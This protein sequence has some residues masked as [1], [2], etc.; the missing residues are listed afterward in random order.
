MTKIVR[1][2]APLAVALLAAV[3]AP[4]QVVDEVRPL[5][6]ERGAV[7]GVKPALRV[8]VKGEDLVKMRFKIEL[9]RDGFDTIAATFD[10]QKDPNGWAFTDA[11]WDVKGALYQVRQ[12][13]PDGTYEWRVSAWN[14]V[15]WVAG[16]ST[17]SF[18]VDAV[19]PADVDGLTMTVDRA[20]KVIHLEWRPVQVDIEG[21]P[22]LVARYHVYRYVRK[23]FFASYAVYEVGTTED[24]AFD[25]RDEAA[26]SG[27]LLFYKVA[28]EDAAGNEQGRRIH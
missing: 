20:R 8:A 2:A 17:S 13:L 14:G 28:A 15:D 11:G 16:K 5:E 1:I 3:R 19:P 27:N 7:V 26:F 25:D 22:E 6:P 21:H 12:D 10:Q 23:W 4:A 24:T 9:S 18:R